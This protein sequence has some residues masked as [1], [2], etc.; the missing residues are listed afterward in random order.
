M[1][2]LT[3]LASHFCLRA[4]Q[5]KKKKLWHVV[6]CLL[7]PAVITHT[8]HTCWFFPGILSTGLQMYTYMFQV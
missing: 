3:V 8:P 2:L 4:Y 5:V 7:R 1:F 6:L